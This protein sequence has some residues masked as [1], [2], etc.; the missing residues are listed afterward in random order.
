ML[1]RRCCSCTFKSFS[2]QK[3]NLKAEKIA[4]NNLPFKSPKERR[5]KKQKRDG[6]ASHRREEICGREF[7]NPQKRNKSKT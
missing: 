3:R 4:S 6:S 7:K 5:P 2:R 1:G